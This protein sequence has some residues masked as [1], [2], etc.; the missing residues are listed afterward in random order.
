LEAAGLLRE[1][2]GQKRN[3]LYRYEPYLALFEQH[4]METGAQGAAQVSGSEVGN[5]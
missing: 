2:T 1:T 5:G 4:G 3:R